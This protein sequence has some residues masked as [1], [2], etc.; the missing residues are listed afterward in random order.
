MIARRIQ[1]KTCIQTECHSDHDPALM[2]REA[3]L[4]APRYP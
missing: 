4:S 2:E 3:T 1:R